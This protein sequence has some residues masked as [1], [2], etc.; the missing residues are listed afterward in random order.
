MAIELHHR[1]RR[2]AITVHDS[3]TIR[4]HLQQPNMFRNATHNAR[5]NSGAS[6]LPLPSMGPALNSAT[7]KRYMFTYDELNVNNVTRATTIFLLRERARDLRANY[8]WLW[9]FLAKTPVRPFTFDTLEGTGS[10]EKR[11]ENLRRYIQGHVNINERMRLDV[12]RNLQAKIRW[13]RSN[14]GDGRLVREM[15][16]LS[17]E[18]HS[19]LIRRDVDGPFVDWPRDNIAA[20][21]SN[22]DAA[23]VINTGTRE[24]ERMQNIVAEERLS[25]HRVVMEE[26]GIQKPSVGD[27]IL[28]ARTRAYEKGDILGVQS[29]DQRIQKRQSVHR[30]ARRRSKARKNALK[31]FCRELKF[32]N[33]SPDPLPE[34]NQ[35]LRYRS[36]LILHFFLGENK[37]LGV[38]ISKKNHTASCS[39][40]NR[41]GDVSF[42]IR[43]YCNIISFP[44]ISH[45]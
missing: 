24:F 33:R 10:W 22:Q 36:L 12:N 43:H 25:E 5:K 30:A 14:R 40:L 4:C 20:A 11:A 32:N 2:G 37:L 41:R 9:K 13:K 23:A 7:A 19:E 21:N 3:T 18:V 42:G 28:A 39:K 27:N 31:Q 17:R 15:R 1:V 16:N 35:L 26:I 8:E 44:V 34:M 38:G 45:E 29:A 6:R